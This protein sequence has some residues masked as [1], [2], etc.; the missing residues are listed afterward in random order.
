MTLMTR[1]AL[2]VKGTRDDGGPQV[3]V[4]HAFR[5]VETLE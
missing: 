3:G 1:R 4:L 5:L 2:T